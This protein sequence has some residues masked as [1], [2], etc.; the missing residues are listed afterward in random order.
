MIPM[1]YTS[2]R[3]SNRERAISEYEL[4]AINLE[5]SPRILFVELTQ[6]CNLHCR[7][8]RSATRYD[9]NRD[10]PFPLF[11][12]VADELF[13]LAEIVDLRGHGE[14]TMM[15]NFMDYVDYSLSFGCQLKL[16]TNLTKRDPNMWE[17]L[18][19]SGFIL[20]VS[21]DGARTT[22]LETLRGGSKF[23][24]IEQ[25]LR[26]V[27]GYCQ[28]HNC[29]ADSVYLSCVVQNANLSEIPD[30]VE[31]TANHGMRKLKIF[32]LIKNWSDP[33]HLHHN[34]EA[35]VSMLDKSFSRA[36][37]L[38]VSLELGASLHHDLVIESS[39]YSRCV[40]PWMV[41]LIDYRGRVSYCDHLI[42]D[43]KFV[44]GDLSI[45]SFRSI[46]NSE[47]FRELREQHVSR[48]QDAFSGRF[49]DCEWCYRFR[50]TDYE[51]ILYPPQ[52]NRLVSSQKTSAGYVHHAP[53]SLMNSAEPV[54]FRSKAHTW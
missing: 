6:N 10:M 3:K 42:G 24:I 21:F 13:P 33:N 20:A 2:L 14:S 43:P 29:P 17:R 41:S 25:N 49:I 16:Y 19:A 50:Y 38:G 45:A 35:I 40:H 30:L 18:V 31:F 53:D 48:R 4:G 22:T 34:P 37:E 39:V 12:R 7:M 44:L 11:K 9:L 26:L 28:K 8:C 15:P 54:E 47:R 23:W 27:V 1:S 46:W 5:C 32:P 52:T 36:R 51:H